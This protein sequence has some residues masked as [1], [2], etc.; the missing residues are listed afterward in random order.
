MLRPVVL[1]PQAVGRSLHALIDEARLVRLPHVVV[2]RDLAEE[3][4]EPLGEVHRSEVVE[5]GLPAGVL[6]H[7]LDAHVERLRFGCFELATF[8]GGPRVLP[9]ALD[10]QHLHGHG[11][12]SEMSDF[13]AFAIHPPSTITTSPVWKL[14][15]SLMKYTP[16]PSKSAGVPIRPIGL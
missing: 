1:D 15:H 6:E 5:T 12:S 14:D 11:G 7:A 9:H 2:G 4:T 8:L 10:A 3:E 16:I 13:P